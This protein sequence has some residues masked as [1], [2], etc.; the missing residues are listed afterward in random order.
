MILVEPCARASYDVRST[1]ASS[2][3]LSV[4]CVNSDVTSLFSY[5]LPVLPDH[6]NT[7]VQLSSA[8]HDSSKAKWRN[9]SHLGNF[10]KETASLASTLSYALLRLA[11]D[12]SA[13]LDSLL[14]PIQGR[15]MQLRNEKCGGCSLKSA[16]GEQRRRRR[17][18]GELR[19][20][21]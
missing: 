19:T 18:G 9:S 4:C 20:P 7:L 3:S 13:S 17:D 6:R 15:M 21:L 12:H 16:S 2:A 14:A 5:A 11:D 8:S 10:T 1:G